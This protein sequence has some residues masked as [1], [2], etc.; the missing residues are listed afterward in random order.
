MQ[1]QVQLLGPSR[2]SGLAPV[3]RLAPVPVLAL[4]L[5]LVLARA[6]ATTV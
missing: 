3:L 2:V 4:V 5:A 6:R 1:A